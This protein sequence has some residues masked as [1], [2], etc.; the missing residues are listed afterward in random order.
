MTLTFDS[1]R[2][3]QLRVSCSNGQRMKTRYNNGSLSRFS[4]AHE[5]DTTLIARLR[6]RRAISPT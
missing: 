4:R 3:I 5:A 2:E 1:S 6:S